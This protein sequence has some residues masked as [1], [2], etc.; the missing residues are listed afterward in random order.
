MLVLSCYVEEQQ[1]EKMRRFSGY[2]CFT[3]LWYLRRGSALWYNI[4]S[5]SKFFKI[6]FIRNELTTVLNNLMFKL[7]C[8]YNKLN[9]ELIVNKITFT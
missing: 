7:D 2:K 3:G 8:K 6:I 5:L 1:K 9:I 4:Q